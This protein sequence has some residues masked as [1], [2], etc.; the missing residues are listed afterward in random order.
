MKKS[1]S[2]I[3]S[4]ILMTQ[5]ISMKAQ[6]VSET[7]Q[8]KT[9]HELSRNSSIPNEIIIRGVNQIAMLWKET[10]G[11]ELDFYTFCKG[12]FCKTPAEKEKLFSRLANNFEV[13]FGHNNRITL[14][15][16][17]P[18][19]VTGYEQLPIDELFATYDINAHFSDDM[20]DN[21]IAFIVALNFPYFTLKEK[22]DNGRY[23]SELHWGYVRL[24][25]YFYSRVPA[26]M[27]Q[28]V[29]AA[30]SNADNYIANYNIPMWLIDNSQNLSF[31]A[32][33][34]K[35]ISHWGL[36]DEIKA[37]Y[38][39]SYYGYTKQHLIYGIMKA[40]IDQSIPSEVMRETEGYRW[41]PIS[42]KTYLFGNIE[43]ETTPEP[44]TRYQHLLN[45]FRALSATDKYYSGN[46]T[47]ISRKFESELEMQL[48]DVENL[49]ISLM[50]SPQ[51][52]Q[53]AEIISKRLGRKLQ[54]FDIWYDGFKSRSSI[55]QGKLDADVREKYPNVAAF[56]KDLPNILVKLGFTPEKS[57]EICKFIQ[58]D[59]SIGA[60][61]AWG[62]EMKSDKSML[63]TRFVNG[64]DYKGYNIGI[65]EFGHTVEQTISLHDVHNYFLKGVPNTAFTEALAFTFQQKDLELL[66]YENNDE[67]VEYL[68][69]LDIFWGCYEIM[70]VSL[71]DINVWKWMYENPNA[72][73]WDLKYATMRIA[74][75]VWNQYY[76]P[77]FGIPDQPIL[78]IYSHMID[79]PLYLSAYPI[80]HIIDF[81]IGNFLKDKNLGDEVC[82]MYAM[83]R[84]TPKLWMERSVGSQINTKEL[85]TSTQTAIHKINE[86]MKPAKKTSK[87]Q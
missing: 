19:H 80:G 64:M 5:S 55:D 83:G 56:Q 20:F 69:T 4:I 22:E 30:V 54:P 8:A 32:S 74:K 34:T 39:D 6:F 26:N 85:L 87:K 70:G 62:A 23:W 9:I 78:A 46:S 67:L 51:V 18:I 66:D 1:L 21:K 41:K 31:W 14:D 82:R 68:N 52:K 25:D 79:A 81:Q 75:E 11:S 10:D 48:I 53:V 2:L 13:I 50:T 47:F 3:F 71:V 28:A 36:R 45:I 58:T 49:F 73:A 33:E 29:T 37:A 42:N 63:R 72:T 38:S 40:I 65:H 12:N 43:V 60:G 27:Q 17:R 76:A 86:A 7:I 24:G 35:L 44:N 16:L 15:L 61:H 57:K 84:V 77:V 59:P